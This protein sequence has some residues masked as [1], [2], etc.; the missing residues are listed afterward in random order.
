MP[1]FKPG[2]FQI[3]TLDD[4]THKL[5]NFNNFVTIFQSYGVWIWKEGIKTC[6]KILANNCHG[7]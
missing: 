1:H 6:L 3:N 4:D 2:A 7:S 5:E